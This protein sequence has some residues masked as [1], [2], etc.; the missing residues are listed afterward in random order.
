MAIHH[1]K[2]AY[3]NLEKL[4]EDMAEEKLIK[5]LSSLKEKESG[6]E[7]DDKKEEEEEK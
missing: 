4:Q 6:G 2:H 5:M 1:D 3:G 7:K